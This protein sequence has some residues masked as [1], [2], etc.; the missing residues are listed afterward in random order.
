MH[1]RKA[2]I[3]YFTIVIMKKLILPIVLILGITMI[4][5]FV[6]A[7]TVTI[8]SPSEGAVFNSDSE[9]I[10][11]QASIDVE[12]TC[13]VWGFINTPN[14]NK[15]ISPRECDI[16]S[17]GSGGTYANSVSA[18][19]DAVAGGNYE[20]H[21]TC[22]DRSGQMDTKIVNF[23]VT[24]NMATDTTAPIV[25]IN[26][27]T[28]GG[29]PY[30]NINLD[31]DVNELSSCRYSISPQ[32]YN[33]G[34]GIG[35]S[36]YINGKVYETSLKQSTQYSLT[37]TC[38]DLMGNVGSKTISFTTQNRAC[39]TC[40][41]PSNNTSGSGSSGGGSGATITCSDSDGG[42]DYF[43]KGE[44]VRGVVTD[45]GGSAGAKID[46]CDYKGEVLTE[47]YCGEDKSILSTSYTCPGKCEDGACVE[48]DDEEDNIT[49]PTTSYFKNCNY[50]WDSTP[51][52]GQTIK[53][54]A[55]VKDSSG[56]TDSDF[57]DV[58]V[59]NSVSGGSGGAYYMDGKNLDI[60]IIE[61]GAGDVAGA[62]QIKINSKS[63]NELG[64]MSL[65]LSGNNWGAGFPISNRNCVAGGSGGGGSGG[66][67]SCEKYHVCEDGSEVQYC[68]II[69][70]YDD[71]GNVVGAGCACKQ[72]P[73][74][75]CT[76]S[77]SGGGGGGQPIPINTSFGGGGGS[78]GNNETPIIC[79]GCILGDK[80]VPVGYRTED[81]YCTIDS[82]LI[83]QKE[84][85]LSCNNN[86]ECSTNLCI[87]NQC[88]S[89]NVWQKFLRW[90]SRL[91]GGN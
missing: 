13:D 18:Y 78:G 59:V 29:N 49:T 39:S 40:A 90:I 91:F 63:P 68:E 4:L 83:S 3:V 60:Q 70:Q 81:K 61:P 62:V 27:P 77:S 88:V 36:G 67:S 86:F 71:N 14:G 28:Q 50:V 31:F 82:E 21:A 55:S 33:G 5:G 43:E 37:V 76:S 45:S 22:S 69:K 10:L 42:K 80:C 79:N 87:D 20:I 6:S 1:E 85:S 46:R 75:L 89:S 54:T 8:S 56:S 17:K 15:D 47:Y 73:E 51:Y 30:S 12:S 74:E 52:V 48:G 2:F 41:V 57:V 44:T 84:A 32:D 19:F 53:I 58:S 35:F 25:T 26:F 38:T 24:G 23:Q 16:C 34:S 72:N 9:D 66:G 11:V 65:G 64:E 7:T